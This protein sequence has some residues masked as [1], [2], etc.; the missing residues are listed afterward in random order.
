MDARAPT[1]ARGHPRARR[2]RARINLLL[3]FTSGRHDE[4]IN[5]I[6]INR[7]RGYC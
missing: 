7:M 4:R 2:A 5:D 6:N 1:L 3:I